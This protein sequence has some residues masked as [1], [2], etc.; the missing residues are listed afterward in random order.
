ML[1]VA[2]LLNVYDKTL[3]TIVKKTLKLARRSNISK[4]KSIKPLR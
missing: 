2:T 3:R 4:L 1:D